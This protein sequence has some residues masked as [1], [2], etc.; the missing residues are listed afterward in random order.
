MEGLNINEGCGEA[1]SKVGAASSSHDELVKLADDRMEEDDSHLSK[2]DAEESCPV[3]LLD[4]DI[5]GTVEDDEP[6]VP[7]GNTISMTSEELTQDRMDA[8]RFVALCLGIEGER[9]RTLCC[10]AHFVSATSRR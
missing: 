6:L 5:F 3:E 9:H 7:G 4:S 8:V 1:L 2:S 10:S